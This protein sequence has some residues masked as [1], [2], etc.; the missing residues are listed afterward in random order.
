[1]FLTFNPHRAL[2]FGGR[3][4]L[5]KATLG[6]L[7]D[8]YDKLKGIENLAVVGCGSSLNA[9]NYGVKLMRH[10]GVFANVQAMGHGRQLY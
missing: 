8:N 1:M 3:L 7:D 9:A 4:F 5:D 6:G 10:A 2:G